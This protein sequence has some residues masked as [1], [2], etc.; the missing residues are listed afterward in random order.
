MTI[1]TPSTH[2]ETRWETE[3]GLHFETKRF[4]KLIFDEQGLVQRVE[5]Y[6]PFDKDR[7]EDSRATVHDLSER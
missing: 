6:P 3:L 1:T 5:E 2:D 7:P 4:V